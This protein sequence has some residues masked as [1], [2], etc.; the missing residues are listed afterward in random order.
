MGTKPSQDT[1]LSKL[2]GLVIISAGVCAAVV[3]GVVLMELPATTSQQQDALQVIAGPS[4]T[5]AAAVVDLGDPDLNIE[6]SQGGWVQIAGPDGALAQQYRFDHLDPDPDDLARH[7]LRMTAPHVQMFLHGGRM[8]TLTGQT[9]D[10]YAPK[11]A[12]EQGKLLGDVVIRLYEKDPAHP[13]ADP[14]DGEPAMV[15]RTA[16]ASFDNLAGRIECPGDIQAVSPTER[17]AGRDLL[18]LLNDRDDRIEFLRMAEVDYLVLQESSLPGAT[19]S[20]QARTSRGAITKAA[21]QGLG[22]PQPRPSDASDVDFYHV[23][24]AQDVR[25]DQEDQAGRRLA[26]ADTLDVFFS[27]QSTAAASPGPASV[28]RLAGT[29]GTL[30]DLALAARQDSP[31]PAP[32]AG[33]IVVTCN[34][35]LI[36]V[37][38][39]EGTILPPTADDNRLELHGS[40]V[41]LLDTSDRMGA[42]CTTLQYQSQTDRIDLVGSDTHPVTVVTDDLGLRTEH[43][44]A[45]MDTGLAGSGS[46]PGRADMLAQSPLTAA[47]LNEDAALIDPEAPRALEQDLSIEWTD[48]VDVRFEPGG[49]SGAGQMKMVLFKGNVQVRSVDGEIDANS[50]EMRFTPDEQ[51]QAHPDRMLAIGDVRAHNEDQTLWANT[52]TATLEPPA[53]AVESEEDAPEAAQAVRSTDPMADARIKDFN[54]NGNVQVLLA[55]GARAFADTLNGDARQEVVTLKGDNIVVARSDLLIEHGR[56]IRIERK[57]GRADWPGGG[58][59]RLLARPINVTQDKR[60]VRPDVP[61]PTPEVKRVVTMQARWNDAL[62]Y[63]ASFGNGAGALDLMGQVSVVAQQEPTERAS[64]AG[65]RLRL[66]F[67]SIAEAPDAKAPQQPNSSN[68]FSNEGRVLSRLIATT[69]ARL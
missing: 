22:S 34:G 60:I 38:A 11:R 13:T 1:G 15:F 58:L 2:T 21:L 44:W 26:V 28:A 40:P 17:L 12:L 18:V 50:L 3:I 59:A 25:I 52:L 39:P 43:L 24:L 61:A 33:E 31:V 5:D 27:M 42:L 4:E 47:L 29:L 49:A 32:A 66:E 68:L 53:A 23:R 55:D 46:T 63:D 48:G 36:M 35:P 45:E 30:G 41:R 9:L 8:V 67:T 16:E 7:W 37:P 51:G 69:E 57:E 62:V 54:A 56:E 19:G 65:E 14:T 64:L 20:V 6:L 10:A